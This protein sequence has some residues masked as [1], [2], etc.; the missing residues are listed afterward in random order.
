[1][2]ARN[3]GRAVFVTMSIL[4]ATAGCER[5][6]VPQDLEPLRSQIEELVNPIEGE[7]GVSVR[8]IESGN[9]FDIHGDRQYPTASMY[10]V[11]IMVEAFRQ[12]SE[13]ELDLDRRIAIERDMLHFST[14]LSH[15]DPGLRPTL[16]D[17]IFFMITNSENG[18]TDIVLKQVGAERVTRTMHE[19]GLESISVDRTVKEMMEDYLGLTEEQRRLEGRAFME[20]VDSTP[21]RDH[22]RRMWARSDAAIPEAVAAFSE[23]PK[24]VASPND[25][26]ELLTRIA[27]GDV[28]SPEASQEMLDIMLETVFGP[29]LLPS[30]LPRYTPVARK[31]GTLPTSL[32]ETGII[33]LPEGRGRVVVTVMTNH[34]RETR[35]SAAKLVADIGGATY[36]FFA[37]EAGR[38][39][40]AVQSVEDAQADQAATSSSELEARVRDIIGDYQGE[41][42]VAVEHLES[43]LS[44]DVNGNTPYPL[45]S[46]YKVPMM[47]ELYRQVEAGERS[48]DRRVA[49]S[50]EQWHPWGPI[51]SPFALGIEPTT[52]DLLFWMMVQSDNLA[53]DVLLGQIG[54][55][56]VDAT[57]DRMGFDAIRVDRP[58]EQ[59]FLDYYG[60]TGPEWSDPGPEQLRAA[61]SIGVR[62][63]AER[64]RKA[65]VH[66]SFRE[67]I[68]R[69]NADPQDTGSPL[70]VNRLLIE[71]FRGEVVSPAAS[72]EMIE[73]MLQCRTGEDRL[74]GRLPPETRVAH[75]TGGWP[76]SLNDAG[77][78]YLPGDAGHVAVTVLDNN[79]NEPRDRTA[80][81]IARI[82]REVYDFFVQRASG[83]PPP[84]N[85]S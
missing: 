37:P 45:A 59:L 31:A 82:A 41:V 51:L 42:G 67:S 28:V 27:E 60:L 68:A 64:E 23:E 16:R 25:L 40:A 57:L 58:T 38:R 54:I 4:V 7:V 65:A 63:L 14:V 18:A 6:R 56:N 50:E 34:L 26:T 43:G 75:K 3:V 47:V 49:I 79:M 19:M 83:G 1:M 52:G 24:D 69:Y 11:P 80:D 44:F 15:F 62:I 9:G 55:E 73:I 10:K 78:I 21:E 48:L 32:G 2:L 30:Q 53:T 39:D 29:H 66:G 61:D 74:K 46:V 71:I 13:G 81:M 72:R 77:I 70:Q 5:D 17:L 22:Y 85:V 8:H 20:M 33:F 35:E 84:G 36:Q 76:T 12:A